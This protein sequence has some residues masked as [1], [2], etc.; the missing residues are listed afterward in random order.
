ML[1]RWHIIYGVLFT[2]LFWILSPN[3]SIIN[4]SLILFAAILID[5]DHY[6][7]AVLKTKRFGLKNSF[8]YHDDQEKVLQNNHKKGIRKKADF[9][10]FHTF[11][12]HIIIGALSF[13]WS[14]I[15]YIFIG[16]IFHSILDILSMIQKDRLYLREFFFFN[17]ARKR[18]FK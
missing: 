1:P 5:F 9:H 16:M 12:F 18:F 7:Q 10:F 6:I 14:P 15:F 4:L 11:E 13:L 8:K 3:T 17:W 2:I